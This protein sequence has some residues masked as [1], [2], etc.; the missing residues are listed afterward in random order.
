MHTATA[1]LY[2][3]PSTFTM[4]ASASLTTLVTEFHNPRTQ[5]A[6]VILITMLVFIYDDNKPLLPLTYKNLNARNAK[7]PTLVKQLVEIKA[8]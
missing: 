6:L 5:N 2:L 7:E 1:W 8:L 3:K 4:V